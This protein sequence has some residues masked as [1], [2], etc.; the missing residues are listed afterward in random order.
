MIHL[1]VEIC[2]V[3]TNAFQ[4]ENIREELLNTS[5]LR[6]NLRPVDNRDAEFKAHLRQTKDL[7]T[8]LFDEL[9][10]HM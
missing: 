9:R 4:A 3:V 10:I 7:F 5:R 8:E 1:C 6:C 2:E